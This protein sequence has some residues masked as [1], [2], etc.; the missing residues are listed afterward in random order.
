MTKP[1]PTT[2]LVGIALLA[3]AVVATGCD[4]NDPDE[5]QNSSNFAIVR[6]QFFASRAS[7]T[8]VSG[9]RMIVESDPEAER[10]Y[11][12]PDVVAISGATGLAEAKVFPGYQQQQGQGQGGGGGGAGG[13]QQGPTTPTSP[14][15]FPPG[16]FFAD[17]AVTLVYNGRIVSLIAGGLTIGSGRVYDLGSVFLDDF[18]IFVD[19]GAP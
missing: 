15:D 14:L 7:Q 13:G 16:L 10:P 2:T 19:R 11:R 5:V 6:A 17:V 1:E 12:G 4:W 8:P 3:L 9:V 18:G